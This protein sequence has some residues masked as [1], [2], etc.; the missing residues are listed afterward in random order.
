MAERSNFAD[1]GNTELRGGEATLNTTKT[2][3]IPGTS[4]DPLTTKMV[5]GYVRG[6]LNAHAE[7]G[8]LAPAAVS[9]AVWE[10]NADRSGR[11][12]AE[13]I[14]MTLGG[15]FVWVGWVTSRCI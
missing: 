9:R 1:V 12:R 4:V 3:A 7:T 2:L 8:G 5:Y 10:L 14:D 6:R 11:I 13:S 15:E